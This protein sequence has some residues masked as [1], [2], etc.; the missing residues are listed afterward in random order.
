MVIRYD[1]I[2]IDR[3][4]ATLTVDG[5]V[6]QFKGEIYTGRRRRCPTYSSYKDLLFATAQHLLLNGW[7]RKLDLYEYLYG[8]SADGGP[9]LGPHQIDIQMHQWRPKLAKMGLAIIREKRSSVMWY[10]LVTDDSN[11]S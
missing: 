10:K 5:R 9:N 2:Q 3:E 11:V 8:D 4:T 6:Y 7:T 1:N